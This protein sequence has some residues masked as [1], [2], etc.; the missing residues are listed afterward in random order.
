MIHG[1]LFMHVED[2][3][4]L[5]LTKLRMKKKRT[6]EVPAAGAASKAAV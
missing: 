4:Q 3:K 5:K 1:S 2:G 6:T